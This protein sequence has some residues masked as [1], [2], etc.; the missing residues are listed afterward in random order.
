MSPGL[1]VSWCAIG[2]QDEGPWARSGRGKWFG[3]RSDHLPSLPSRPADA[4]LLTWPKGAFVD[5]R[6]REREAHSELSLG[7]VRPAGPGDHLHVR[8]L[9]SSLHDVGTVGTLLLP[10]R[11]LGSA[12][13]CCR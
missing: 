9:V 11:R 4:G 1:A 3:P 5:Y 2:Q 7:R 12:A 13:W 6:G 8:R 10:L